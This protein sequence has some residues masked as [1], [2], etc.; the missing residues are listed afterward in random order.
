MTIKIKN[1]QPLLFPL[2][3]KSDLKDV[4]RII[5]H[6]AVADP[7]LEDSILSLLGKKARFSLVKG[8]IGYAAEVDVRII[9]EIP[10]L[11]YDQGSY[12]RRMG[13]YECRGRFI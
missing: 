10:N 9:N 11:G 8:S 2:N 7:N 12:L 5:V 6:L 1:S 3:D 13:L 4:S